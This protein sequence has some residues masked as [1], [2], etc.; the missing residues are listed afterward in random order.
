[1]IAGVVVIMTKIF[2]V[3]VDIALTVDPDYGKSSP[4]HTHTQLRASDE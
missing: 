1:M 3:Q 2:E 4:S